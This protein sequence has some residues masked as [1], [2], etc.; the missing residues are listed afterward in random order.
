[1]LL[2]FIEPIWP[3]E[4]RVWC[5]P[6]FSASRGTLF[7]SSRPHTAMSAKGRLIRCTVLGSTPKRLAMP[8]TPSPVRLRSFRAAWIRF[9]RSAAIR[10]R[11]SRF[12]ILG[13]PK[14]GADS[15]CDHRPLKLGKHTHHL[16]H[17]F[18]GRCRPC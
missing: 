5:H 13:P 12:L 9:S 18:A 11:P 2:G 3:D 15:F 14:P 8:R 17:G 16:K 10:G 1:A 6:A 4:W 7:V